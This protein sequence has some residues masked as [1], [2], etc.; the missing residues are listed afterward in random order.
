MGM[1]ATAGPARRPARQ[2]ARSWSA[3]DF[4]VTGPADNYLGRG[5]PS[6]AA[7]SRIQFMCSSNKTTIDPLPDLF[8]VSA[9]GGMARETIPARSHLPSLRTKA[10]A[11]PSP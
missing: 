4:R 2:S 5:D 1:L 9:V 3:W 10:P 8:F 7:A 11:P 6:L